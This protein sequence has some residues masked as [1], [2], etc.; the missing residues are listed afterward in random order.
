M[1][2]VTGLLLL[3]L[4]AQAQ[5]VGDL[6]LTYLKDLIRLDTSNPPGNESRVAQYLKQVADREGV[7]AE[8][9]G[10]DPNRL[11]FVARLKGSGKQRPLL[12]MAHSDVVP[13][14]RSQWT[15]E[16]F[17]AVEKDGYI[18][19][20]G[21]E[22]DKDLL[23]AELA[24]MVDLARRKVALDRD[25]ILLSESDE[26]SGSTGTKW[27]I[28]NAWPKIDAEFALNEFTYILPTAS[29]VPVFQIQTAE[30]IPTRVR[31][32]AHGVAGHGSLPRDD[33]PVLHLARAIVKI[34]EA[35]QP[36]AL[37]S[38]TRT[39]LQKLAT[40]PDYK[41]LSP[42][43][44]KLENA[45]SAGAA[46]NEIRQRDPEIGAM[47]RFTVSP[48]MLNAG[49]KINVI[50]N[51]AEA[52]LDGRRLPTETPEEIFARLRSQ[53]NDPAVT[54]EPAEVGMQPSTEP[55]SLTSPLYLAMESVFK[56]SAASALVVPFMMRGTT[57]GAFLRARGMAVYGVPIFKSDGPL[58]LH[59]ND[60]RIGVENLKNGTGLLQKIVTR[61]AAAQQ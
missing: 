11:N 34:T 39:W 38:T 32:T 53:V 8:L 21:A 61:V 6:A 17:T 3:A 55:S 58:R 56:E 20:R 4:V 30:K 9:L 44:P 12:M 19:G 33:N 28:Q 29:G 7:P 59:G 51:T 57:D 15:L 43:L 22:D 46:A 54:V 49:F 16:P 2:I 52:Q 42:M 50:P 47:L 45:A 36:V 60:E 1:R 27:V 26:E 14:D 23:A 31:L 40:L 10:A 5:S 37:N 24:V 48:T 18:Y 25:V 41:W 35:D 13:V